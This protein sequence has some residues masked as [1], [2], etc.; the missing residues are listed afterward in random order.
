M[1][2]ASR[3]CQHTLHRRV[4]LAKTPST[5]LSHMHMHIRAHIHT[6][7]H[8]YRHTYVRTVHRSIKHYCSIW[9]VN[10]H[11]F[12]PPPFSPNKR[13]SGSWGTGSCARNVKNGQWEQWNRQTW[14]FARTRTNAGDGH[15]TCLPVM[16]WEGLC[17][18]VGGWVLR[19]R[20]CV[21]TC[22]C[23]SA[24][25]A[26]IGWRVVSNLLTHPSLV[27]NTCLSS[28]PRTRAMLGPAKNLFQNFVS[29][30]GKLALTKCN[31]RSDGC[32]MY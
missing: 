13:P 26:W 11:F 18:W 30:R 22:L 2:A 23:M 10:G 8:T 9:H 4:S 12:P 5:S 25:A 1:S 3:A 7:I 31:A 20:A 19:A 14:Q 27:C 21:R 28:K 32:F 16:P 24:C 29:G 6:Y 17:G 15:E